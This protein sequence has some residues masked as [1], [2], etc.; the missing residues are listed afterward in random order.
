MA[1]THVGT[2]CTAHS[3]ITRQ[4]RCLP[5]Q[6]GYQTRSIQSSNVHLIIQAFSRT[7]YLAEVGNTSLLPSCR[8]IRPFSRPLNIIKGGSLVTSMKT[9]RRTVHR[10][11][12]PV[13]KTLT[14]RAPRLLRVYRILRYPNYKRMT[15]ILVK[16]KDRY[17]DEV[18]CFVGE[19]EI[20]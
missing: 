9:A 4:E 3:S 7:V 5:W 17:W 2:V 12:L 15:Q 1:S 20:F 11:A 13:D 10:D 19:E 16:S 14:V 8:C 18:A 6:N